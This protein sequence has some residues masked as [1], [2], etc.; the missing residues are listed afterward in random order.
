[1]QIHRPTKAGREDVEEPARIV[2]VHPVTAIAQHMHVV[3]VRPD[4]IPVCPAP[5]EVAALGLHKA[6]RD[7][8]SWVLKKRPQTRRF[9]RPIH[10]VYGS[11]VDLPDKATAVWTRHEV[12]G[13]PLGDAYREPT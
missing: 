2:R 3:A 5:P 8:V 9:V 11:Q 13:G 10:L 6:H 1:M 7:T 4:Q 12:G